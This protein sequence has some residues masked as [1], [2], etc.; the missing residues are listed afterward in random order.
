MDINKTLFITDLDGTLLAPVSVGSR[1]FF[2][3]DERHDVLEEIHAASERV[4]K[5]SAKKGK[6][7]AEALSKSIKIRIG[8][9]VRR[10]NASHAVIVPLISVAG[11]ERNS[12][13]WLEKELF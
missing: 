3:Q 4:L 7:D 1:G 6:I 12:T 8:D 11:D 2:V 13:N 10:R 9:V 5:E